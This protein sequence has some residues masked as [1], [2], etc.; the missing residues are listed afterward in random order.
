MALCSHLVM[1]PLATHLRAYR[2]VE[3]ARMLEHRADNIFRYPWSSGA[4]AVG[5]HDS[6]F[7]HQI[8]AQHMIDTGAEQ[9]NPAE[10][11][12]DFAEAAGIDVT[13]QHFAIRHCRVDYS[14]EIGTAGFE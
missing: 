11:R 2:Q 3:T 1:E 9:M 6:A 8:A 13:Q 14:G 7:N 10:T 5:Q 4:T 12:S